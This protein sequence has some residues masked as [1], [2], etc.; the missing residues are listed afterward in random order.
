M[1]LP[2]TFEAGLTV[3]R[4]ILDVV[5]R[6]AVQDLNVFGAFGAM[7]NVAFTAVDVILDLYDYYLHQNF[8][9]RTNDVNSGEES[10]KRSYDLRT[11][12]K[13]RGADRHLDFVIT[14]NSG[15]GASLI[16]SMSARMLLKP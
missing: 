6:P 4:L 7:I 3:V 15:S 1:G 8:F 11:A 5:I 12:R 9:V 13:I 10:Y 14:N 16:W 2:K